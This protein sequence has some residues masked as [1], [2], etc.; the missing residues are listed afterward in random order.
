MSWDSGLGRIRPHAASAQDAL[1]RLPPATSWWDVKRLHGPVVRL[2]RASP[3]RGKSGRGRSRTWCGK[4]PS[5]PALL[6]RWPRSGLGAGPIDTGLYA[7]SAP[8]CLRYSTVTTPTM[9]SRETCGGYGNIA[10][11]LSGSGTN[12]WNVEHEGSRSHG[13]ASTRSSC[14]TGCQRQGSFT[15][16]PDGTNLT[17]EEPDAL[18]GARPWQPPRIPAPKAI[19]HSR[20]A[21]WLLQHRPSLLSP[22]SGSVY[23]AGAPNEGCRQ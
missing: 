5:K 16:T 9:A 20:P 23:R 14:V 8:G 2:P 10:I 7:S 15:A 1:H 4:Q 3:T 21:R 11:K 12:G 17:R 18:C 13:R 19:L 6:A 22:D